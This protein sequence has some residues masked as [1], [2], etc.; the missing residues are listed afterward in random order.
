MATHPWRQEVNAL[1]IDVTSMV[2]PRSVAI[3]GASAKRMTQGN[4]V[5][6]NLKDWGYGGA[7]L[8]VHPQAAEIDGL[9]A[10]NSVAALPPETD[11]AIVAIPAAQVEG[12]LGELA[13]S[14]VRSAIVFT[15]GFSAE[16]ERALRAMDAPERLIVHGPNCMGLVNFTDSVPLYPSRPSKRLRPGKVAL[17]AQSGSAAISVMNS[18]V[19]GFSKVVTVGSEFHVGAADYIRWLA[20]DDATTTIG[21]V[22]ESIKDPVALAL[23]AEAV[24]AAGKS[25]V[26]L[27][28]GRTASGMAA[29]AAHT[30]ALVSDSDA[31]EDFFASTNIATVD[32]YDGLVAALECA[33]VTRKMVAGAAIGIMGISGGQTALACDIAEARGIGIAT[34]SD[35]TAARVKEAQPGVSGHNPVDFGATV[36]AEERNSTVAISA[37]LEDPGVAAVAVLQDTQE[38]LN[39]A[40]LQNYMGVLTVYAEAGRKAKKPFVV[41]S[42]TSENVDPGVRA[43]LAE[44]GVPLLR[45]LTPG[46]G[47]VGTLAFGKPGPAGAW[48]EAR[49]PGRAPHNPRAGELRRML[50]GRSGALDP[51]TAFEVLRAYGLPVV[52]SIVARDADEAVRRAGEVGFPM[53]VKV[54]SATIQHRSD[55]GGVVLDVADEASLR[56]AIG[57]I[58]ASVAAARPDATIDGYEMQE[59]LVDGVEAMAGFTAAAP[60]GPLVVAGSGGTLV[61]V[62]ADRAV[63]LA[64]LSADEARGMLAQTKLAKILGGYRNLMPETDIAPLADVVAKLS[65]LACDLD[66][67][68]VACDINPVLVRKG[69]GEVRIVDALCLCA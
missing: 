23:A 44:N 43:F 21:V 12:V 11:T 8:P 55:V 26:V 2:R 50:A 17:I 52:K 63:K 19:I 4:V 59:Q 53:V 46:L 62:M 22:A 67:V 41:I 1:H 32:D 20:D 58:A 48:A 64:P 61:E 6:A 34:F 45:G 37:V 30:G 36:N 25:L 49:R 9:K 66:G 24:H 35:E 3:I 5:I 13:Q 47:A 60:F 56:A 7:V 10:F 29:T 27:K 14:P 42:P 65:Q 18:T 54:A 38:S 39:P 57:R 68:L 69:T 40:T 33:A 28:V 15:N 16:E 31:H 51:A